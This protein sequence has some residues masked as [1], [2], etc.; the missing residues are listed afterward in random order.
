MN[1]RDLIGPQLARM[2][3]LSLLAVA[4]GAVMSVIGLVIAL[5]VAPGGERVSTLSLQQ[6]GAQQWFAGYLVAFMFV[7]GL[8]GGS[9]AW[10]MIGHIT[11]GGWA[12]ILR[13][14]LEAGARNLW[15][16]FAMFVPILFV[17]WAQNGALYPWTNTASIREEHVRHIVDFK[18][19]WLNP[20][21]FTI[22]AIVYFVIWGLFARAL[23]AWSRAQNT[24]DDPELGRKLNTRSA[25]GLLI[26]VMTMTF[27][28]IDWVMSLMPQWYSSLFGVIF[29]VG[30]GL[31]T[32]ALMTVLI[33][34]LTINTPIVRNIEP[35]Y[36][37]DLGNLHLAFTLLWG[38][39]NISQF[40]LIWS[41]N[42]PEEA[43]WYHARISWQSGWIWLGVVLVFGHFWIPFFCLISSALK[44]NIRHLS[45]LSLYI[46]LM[47]LLDLYFYVVPTLRPKH[48]TAT[49]LLSDVGL[50]VL[51]T[52]LWLWRW[53]A[54]LKGEQVVAM[55]DPRV[56]NHRET[57][58]GVLGNIG[59]PGYI[60]GGST[61][62]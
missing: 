52:G 54:E 48:I 40:M 26:F 29:I 36:F 42:L 1:I 12:L 27:A 31:S 50:I 2:Q 6:E 11:G 15:L 41:A 13:R 59:Q 55:Q 30:Q 34:A 16:V 44:V 33:N 3:R 38:Y 32:L 21:G 20:L 23:V 25:V 22:R 4:V 37:R 35:R 62:A 19:P 14:P 47:R 49:Y 17:V 60:A 46:L 28:S 5:G 7:M 56:Q 51:L 45:K 58:Q 43:E 57:V 53:A 61:H 39:M 18:K 24:S 9:L 8:S 10:L